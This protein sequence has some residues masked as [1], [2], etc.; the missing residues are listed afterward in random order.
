M[1]NDAGC[2]IMQAV[3]VAAALQR[4]TSMTSDKWIEYSRIFE[5]DSSEPGFSARNL[6]NK[7]ALKQTRMQ[8][9]N[10][11]VADVWGRQLP[12][13]VRRGRPRWAVDDAAWRHG[14]RGS[15]LPPRP[16][17]LYFLVRLI[18]A[19]P[20]A[21]CRSARQAQLSWYHGGGPCDPKE[22]QQLTAPSLGS[23]RTPTQYTLIGEYTQWT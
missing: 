19:E 9:K 4:M 18:H 1:C 23:A 21:P 10:A 3:S 11:K 14:S 5:A 15:L 8:K 6:L 20:L 22:A 16:L 13:E 2:V 12:A 7:H 17:H